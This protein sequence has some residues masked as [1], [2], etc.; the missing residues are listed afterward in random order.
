MP[1]GDFSTWLANDIINHYLRSGSPVYAS[2]HTDDPGDDA[3]PGAVSTTGGSN[4]IRKLVTFAAP[5]A[6]VT[7]NTNLVPYDAAGTDWGLLTH[8][9]VWDAE[10]GGHL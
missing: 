5:D 6:G 10:E 3:G 8:F 7:S 4:Y 9:G 2:L 1:V